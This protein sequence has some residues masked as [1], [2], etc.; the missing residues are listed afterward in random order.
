MF[1]YPISLIPA[2]GVALWTGAQLK[3]SNNLLLLFLHLMR[4]PS[5]SQ[6]YNQSVKSDFF[7]L[8]NEILSQ[9][10]SLMDNFRPGNIL[11]YRLRIQN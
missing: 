10:K 4:R 9:M 3:T 11:S 6:F 2:N 8:V 1:F 5:P 7:L